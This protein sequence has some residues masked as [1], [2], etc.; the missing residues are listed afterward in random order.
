MQGGQNAAGESGRSEDPNAEHPQPRG[1]EKPRARAPELGARSGPAPRARARPQPLP[2]PPLRLRLPRA[3][4]RGLP[5]A[6]P[7]FAT[8]RMVRRQQLRH[9]VG[10]EEEGRGG[11]AQ[12]RRRGRSRRRGR[13]G[14]P[15][16][17]KARVGARSPRISPL[18]SLPATGHHSHSTAPCLGVLEPSRPRGFFSCFLPPPPPQ[19]PEPRTQTSERITPFFLCQSHSP[20]FV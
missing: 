13:A 2:R 3:R 10:G 12:V 8:C 19:N 1:A 14:E 11:G 5:C 4:T 9:G 17:G 15:G 7:P 20:A 18:A 16:W 6:S